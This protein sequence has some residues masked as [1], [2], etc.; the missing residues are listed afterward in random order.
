MELVIATGLGLAVGARHAFEPD[1]LAA[2]STLVAEQPRP[3][4]A[5][6]LGA[7]WGLGHTA[8][9]IAVGLVLVLARAEL[10]PAVE[11]GFELVVAAMLIVLGVRAVRAALRDGTT[12]A[13]HVHHHGGRAHVHGGP[14]A[15][16]HVGARALA[17]RPLV[18]GVIHG[19][20]GS[21]ALAALAM[22]EVASSPAAVGYVAS[23]GLGSV[24]G[25]AAVSGLAAMSLAR[26]S[27]SART[28]RRVRVGSGAFAIAI[29]VA[30]GALALA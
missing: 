29:G 23:F 27:V 12:G 15:H 19:L 4:Q 11:R 20:A 18:V 26:L 5:A 16:I 8:A 30:W 17:L 13:P 1:H 24:V 2:V 3:R 21:G 6:L 22:A 28:L 14:P 10:A 25:M 9:L 7:L